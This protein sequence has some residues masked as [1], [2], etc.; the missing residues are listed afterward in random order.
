MVNYRPV[1]DNRGYR[2]QVDQC[3][4]CG[5]AVILMTMRVDVLGD[6]PADSISPTAVVGSRL[7]D[8]PTHEIDVP[9]ELIPWLIEHLQDIYETHQKEQGDG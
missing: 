7:E 4:E 5:G 2:W 3:S 8:E 9:P 1:A 6:A